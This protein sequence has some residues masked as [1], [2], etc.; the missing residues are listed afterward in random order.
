MNKQLEFAEVA[1]APPTRAV[2]MRNARAV[3]D[4]VLVR[5]ID[6]ADRDAPGWIDDALAKIHVFARNQGGA[7]FTMETL[8]WVIQRELPQPRELR[9]YGVLTRIAL[10]RGY[11]KRT[12]R[13]APTVSSNGSDRPLYAKG[14][15]A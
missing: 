12:G 5:L 9:V 6:S 4:S 11:I 1:I 3:A 2:R 7:L 8:R 10:K 14:D 15:R 13:S